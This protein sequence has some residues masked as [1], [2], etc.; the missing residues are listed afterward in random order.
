[1]SP[2]RSSLGASAAVWCL[3][4]AICQPREVARDDVVVTLLLLLFSALMVIRPFFITQVMAQ[5]PVFKSMRWPFRELVQ[6]QFFLHLFLVVRKPGFTA[7]Q[8]RKLSADFR[9]VCLHRAARALSLTRRRS[10]P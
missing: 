5:L 1:M 4:P 7:T 3:L 9:R 6:F 2:T 10:T 8:S